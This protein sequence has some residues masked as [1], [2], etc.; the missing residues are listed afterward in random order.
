MGEAKRRAAAFAEKFLGEK[1][2][3]AFAPATLADALKGLDRAREAAMLQQ[4]YIPK[5][6]P[7]LPYMNVRSVTI[8]HQPIAD[9]ARPWHLVIEMDEEDRKMVLAMGGTEADAHKLAR[10]IN[11][12]EYSIYDM[13][14]GFKSL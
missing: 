12:G 13:G 4:Q 3:P 7:A 11:N 2:K 14:A 9:P 8:E 6:G 10:A 1:T 5:P